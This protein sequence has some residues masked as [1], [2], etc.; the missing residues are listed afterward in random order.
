MTE[1]P[2]TPKRILQETTGRTMVTASPR[3]YTCNA[4][5]VSQKQPVPGMAG[6]FRQCGIKAMRVDSHV[7]LESMATQSKR[8]ASPVSAQYRT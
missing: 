2:T 4:R 3:Q 8:R 6:Q 1:L 7:T 5:C